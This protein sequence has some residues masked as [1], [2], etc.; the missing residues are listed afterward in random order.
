MQGLLT[1]SSGWW[2]WRNK[3]QL[4]ADVCREASWHQPVCVCTKAQHTR[5]IHLS[6]YAKPAT[7]TGVSGCCIM[8]SNSFGATIRHGCANEWMRIQKASTPSDSRYQ[9]YLRGAQF[10]KHPAQQSI[11]SPPSIRYCKKSWQAK[12]CGGPLQLAPR[13]RSQ[14][15]AAAGFAS[16]RMPGVSC[17][18]P[19]TCLIPSSQATFLYGFLLLS[20]SGVRV[21]T[22]GISTRGPTA[23]VTR[24]YMVSP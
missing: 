21:T 9:E 5:C 4:N 19:R 23:V 11:I 22:G 13:Q 10:G 6:I 14:V 7:T 20:I 3:G 2:A 8:P 17:S 12:S 1:P 15:L 18:H 16:V 24:S